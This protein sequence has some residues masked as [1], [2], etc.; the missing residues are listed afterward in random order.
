MEKLLRDEL[1]KWDNDAD[2][3]GRASAPGSATVSFNSVSLCLCLSTCLCRATLLV[4]IIII[5]IIIIFI[6]LFNT[7]KQQWAE[8]TQYI[9]YNTKKVL[10]ITVNRLF[11]TLQHSRLYFSPRSYQQITINIIQ[12]TCQHIYVILTSGCKPTHNRIIKHHQV[13]PKQ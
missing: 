6:Y 9:Q 11:R 5:I 12:L 10:Q 4:I 7:P 3:P 8:P 2:M 13:L 1:E